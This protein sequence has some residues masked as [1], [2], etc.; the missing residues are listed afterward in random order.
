MFT[1]RM[2]CEYCNQIR[3]VEVKME[4]YYRKLSEELSHP[5]YRRLFAQLANEEREHEKRVE[6]IVVLFDGG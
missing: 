4:N 1:N 3:E 6:A 2:F 5:E